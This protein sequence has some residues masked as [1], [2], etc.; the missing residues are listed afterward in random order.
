L[1]DPPSDAHPSQREEQ[2]TR[3]ALRPP[4]KVANR[5]GS[6]QEAIDQQGRGPENAVVVEK[7]EKADRQQARVLEDQAADERIRKEQWFG[8]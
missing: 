7:V 3:Q 6:Q 8:G 2:Q 4:G 1:S 5:Y